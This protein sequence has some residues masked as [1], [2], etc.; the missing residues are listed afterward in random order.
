MGTK[1]KNGVQRGV[2]RFIQKFLGMQPG[3]RKLEGLLVKRTVETI[4]YAED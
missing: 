4:E 2:L 3:S 1:E